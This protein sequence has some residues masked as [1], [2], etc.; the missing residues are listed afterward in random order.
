M[1]VKLLMNW[2][3]KPGRDQEYFEFVVRE[4]VPG[5]Q[6][7]GLQP[8][9]AWYTVYSRS[10]ETPQMMTEGIAKDLD[11]MQR[12]LTSADWTTLHDRLT[13]FVHNYKHKI[14]HVTGG[15]QL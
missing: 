2:D 12:I 11:A 4:W 6:R 8:T 15:F 10:K 7:L 9:G 1:S 14:V 5:V 3:I 13:E